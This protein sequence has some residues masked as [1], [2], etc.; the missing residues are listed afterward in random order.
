MNEHQNNRRRPRNT[1][2]QYVTRNT[3]TS[4]LEM[5]N[6][7]MDLLQK[8]IELLNKKLDLIEK[9]NMLNS[10]EDQRRNIIR[11][12]NRQT[13]KPKT[14]FLN[15]SPEISMIFSD[16]L[17]NNKK[18]DEGVLD[19]AGSD[20]FSPIVGMLS[21][22]LGEP[23]IK[24][25]ETDSDSE[26]EIEE[27]VVYNSDEEIEELDTKLETIQD[28]IQLGEQFE[29]K[30]N[31]DRE[32]ESK[33]E[34]EKIQEKEK[35]K[36]GLVI[37]NIIKL[38]G[39]SK[40]KITNIEPPSLSA[41]EKILLGP[42]ILD[43]KKPM[44]EK[45]SEENDVFN[46]MLA[47]PDTIKIK[48]EPISC[49]KNGLFE[50]QGKKYPINLETVK[51]LRKPLTKLDSMIGLNSV[52]DS[53]LDMILYYLQNFES[54]NNNM[55]HTV[56]EGPPGVGKTELGRIMAE[57]YSALGII[58]SNKF[59]IVRRTDLVG[60]YL[61][62]TAHRTQ[63][64]IDEAD[65]G[66]L[67]IDEAYSLGSGDK[68]DSFSKECI[69][70]LNQ[71]LS[72]KKRKLIVIIAGYQDELDKSFFSYNPGLR[73]RFPFKFTIDGYS[74]TELRDIFLKKLK[75]S[76]WKVDDK[77]LDLGYLTTFFDKNKEKFIHY[78]G[79]IETLIVDCK[80]MHSRRMVGKHP[81]FRKII[82]KTDIERGLDKFVKNRS[83]NTQMSDSVQSMYV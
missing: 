53:I 31:G 79:D 25:P 14:S 72:E 42:V 64:A 11:R 78:G 18:K 39:N 61:G 73:R 63:K 8:E 71:N 43:N 4:L 26:K 67:F 65:G 22:L 34:N 58:P 82:T 40:S 68:R 3:D 62:H 52:K 81:K 41:I 1:G 9:T 69:D 75:D 6:R 32:K 23:K 24:R 56:I 46:L 36:D 7:K 48:K 13:I 66:V 27:E 37:P 16:S 28:L 80:F 12:P 19:S 20:I 59:K 45:K 83:K 38:D 47:A 49:I 54:R 15:P 55:L 10:N 29:K 60:E 30:Y 70:T 44:L 2:N 5:L 17:F 76:R 35:A 77:E 51:K 33:E 57:V 21:S 74:S 50:Y